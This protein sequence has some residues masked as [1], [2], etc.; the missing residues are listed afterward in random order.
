MRR[1]IL[2][3]FYDNKQINELAH[4]HDA[5]LRVLQEAGEGEGEGKGEL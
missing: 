2:F 4:A 3:D 5:T 1:H